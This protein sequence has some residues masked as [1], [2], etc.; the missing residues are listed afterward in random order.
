MKFPARTAD[1]DL[2]TDEK[3]L[4]RTL[5]QR[6]LQTKQPEGVL[7]LLRSIITKI[8]ESVTA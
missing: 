1:I 5:V 3:D 7:G 2:T 8:A 4:V 6:H